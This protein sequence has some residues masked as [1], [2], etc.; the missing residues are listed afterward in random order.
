MYGR[1]SG[2]GPVAGTSGGSLV[3][4]GGFSPIQRNGS[5]S[6]RQNVPSSTSNTRP[7]NGGYGDGSIFATS[8][9]LHNVAKSKTG[10][11]Y[12]G[13]A[14]GAEREDVNGRQD[15]KSQPRVAYY[16]EASRRAASDASDELWGEHRASYPNSPM[17]S[18]F[19]VTKHEA[20]LG[21]DRRRERDSNNDGD[22]KKSTS[23]RQS[24]KPSRR[25][26]KLWV[27]V[28]DVLQS[29]VKAE[30]A[31]DKIRESDSPG[32]AQRERAANIFRESG[33]QTS[34]QALDI[35]NPHA[36]LKFQASL[37]TELREVQEAL[38]EAQMNV[39]A[40][41]ADKRQLV[42]DLEEATRKSVGV[43]LDRKKT[44]DSDIPDD[45]LTPSQEEMDETVHSLLEMITS[46]R[47]KA[48]A[49][50]LGLEK[51]TNELDTERSIRITSQRN[52]AAHKRLTED[53]F[54]TQERKLREATEIIGELRQALL[55]VMQVREGSVYGGSV[56]GGSARGPGSDGGRSNGSRRSGN[57]WGNGTPAHRTRH[58][59]SHQPR[60][61]ARH[62]DNTNDDSYSTHTRPLTS[63]QLARAK[64][65]S[66]LRSEEA[67]RLW[68]RR[69]RDGVETVVT[70]AMER[71]SRENFG[72]APEPN[73]PLVNSIA[74][75]VRS[76]LN[77]VV[78]MHLVLL[79][80]EIRDVRERRDNA[81]TN[82]TEQLDLVTS[83]DFTNHATD[84]RSKF[85]NWLTQEDSHRSRLREQLKVLR[86]DLAKSQMGR[87]EATKKLGQATM[88]GTDNALSVASIAAE[89]AREVGD[90]GGDIVSS[91]SGY[92]PVARS[93]HDTQTTPV[94]FKGDWSDVEHVARGAH[95][96][97]RRITAT[98]GF[99]LAWPLLLIAFLLRLQIGPQVF[100][101]L[102]LK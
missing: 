45:A 11:S 101:W 16:G 46:E 58:Q 67:V 2:R 82:G 99:E 21:D 81:N 51:A 57:G 48:Y 59:N 87:E 28:E 42:R 23:R 22:A 36:Q 86:D 76:V 61:D 52:F 50:E 78:E 47:D 43:K 24:S 20:S 84:V 97:L 55:S 79:V 75:Q 83:G 9:G 14:H 77:E 30:T 10:S 8:N 49:Y 12:A 68:E 39:K 92:D 19:D 25:D 7:G 95:T 66:K 60:D 37:Q 88:G 85:I 5:H 74:E 4:D 34:V 44:D 3:D 96:A 80:E 38:I 53:E 94:S 65:D 73:N 100:T 72:V 18:S 32:K 33:T 13:S 63:A 70:S 91:T 31:L 62:R 54:F 1:G 29:T 89:A 69:L 26:P 93:K 71:A 90:S 56:V 15:F 17:R 102:S 27:R 6:T 41:Q 64:E 98:Q 40:L 35:N